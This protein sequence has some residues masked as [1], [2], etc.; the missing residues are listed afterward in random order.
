MPYDPGPAVVWTVLGCW[1]IFAGVWI[2]GWVYNLLHAPKVRRRALSP[3]VLIGAG[4]AWFASWLVP[5]SVW[6]ALVVVNPILQGFGI[7][8]VFAGTAF[9]LWARFTLGTMWTGIPSQRAG[10]QLRTSGPFAMARHPIYTGVLAM[11]VGTA[12]ACG[13]GP[14]AGPVIAGAIGLAL[15]MRVEE[16][17]LL[18]TF[19]PEYEAYRSRVRALL[20]FPRF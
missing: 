5:T 19:G 10:H 3:S 17:M 18:E 20:P 9:A 16:K 6:D 8:L 11:L 7:A 4:I 12:L 1:L 2:V 13:I 15:K 14:Y